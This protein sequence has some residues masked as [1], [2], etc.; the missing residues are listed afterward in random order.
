M[1]VEM[2]IEVAATQAAQTVQRVLEGYQARLRASIL[3]TRRR[4][5]VF[6]ERYS[7]STTRFL[8]D[9]TAEDLQGGDLEYVDW[10]G[11]A[12]LFSGLEAELSELE[13]ARFQLQ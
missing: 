12:G 7:V 4:L 1:S 3:R 9:M 2:V 13:N 5:A 8:E 6:E 11:E 10:A